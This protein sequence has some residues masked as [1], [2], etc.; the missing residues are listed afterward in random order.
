[1]R[2]RLFRGVT[3]IAAAAL[4]AL[5]LTGC[6]EFRPTELNQ[7]GDDRVSLRPLLDPDAIAIPGTDTR[8][9][10]AALGEPAEMTS[11]K[12]PE[13]ERPGRVRTLRYDGLDIV[14]RELNKPRRRYISDLVITSAAY[15][16]TL[17][18][19]VG[20]RR[21]EIE[22]VLGEPSE[23][24]GREAVYVLTDDGDRCIVAYEDDRAT[25]LTFQ[26]G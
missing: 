10:I 12:P 22:E 7:V 4:V 17:P 9:V 19:G 13:N 25:R 15:A 8:D 24:E 5:G 21:S 20:S 14:V 3:A 1:M 26:Y 16:T 6:A 18:I 23:T 2:E 11:R